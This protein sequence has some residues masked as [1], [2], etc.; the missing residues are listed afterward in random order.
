MLGKGL[1]VGFK[2]CDKALVLLDLFREVPQEIVLQT[3]LLALMVGFH[4]LQ[5]GN[6]HIQV[7]LLLDALVTG[8]QSFDLGVG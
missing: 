4:Q 5:A 8:A 1:H 3:V 7:H 2:A 6:V